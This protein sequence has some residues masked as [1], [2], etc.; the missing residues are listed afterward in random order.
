[1]Q[2]LAR[3]LV[4]TPYYFFP[5]S[6]VFPLYLFC[7][8]CRSPSLPLFLSRLPGIGMGLS[9]LQTRVFLESKITEENKV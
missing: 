6:C 3:V 7:P 5:L 1:M 9:W 8:V 2:I 4:H